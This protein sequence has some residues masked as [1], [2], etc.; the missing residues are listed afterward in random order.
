MTAD[1]T[2]ITTDLSR[3]TLLRFAIAG[4][5]ALIAATVATQAVAGSKIAKKAVR[6]QDTPKGNARCDNCRQW[7][8]PAGCKLVD[9]TI[10]PSGWCS[11]YAPK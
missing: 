3:R 9:G 10:S 5:G 2:N 8:A 11:I 6:Y 7:Q 1:R 4:S